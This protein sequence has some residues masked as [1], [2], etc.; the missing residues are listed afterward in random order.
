MV[1]GHVCRPFKKKSYIKIVTISTLPPMMYP[2]CV[3]YP[4]RAIA[5]RPAIAVEFTND[6]VYMYNGIDLSDIF[7]SSYANN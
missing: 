2:V 5:R 3:L 6:T 4:I 7:Y 1:Y